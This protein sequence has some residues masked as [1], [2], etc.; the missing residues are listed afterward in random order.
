MNFLNKLIKLKIILLLFLFNHYK[1]TELFSNSFLSHF[2]LISYSI[3]L[4][5]PISNHTLQ[6]IT[7]DN[8]D[9]MYISS[10][11]SVYAGNGISWEKINLNAKATLDSDNSKIYYFA[12]ND[13]GSI[14][15]DDSGH[16]IT[17]SLSSLLNKYSLTFSEIS[18]IKALNDSIYIKAGSKLYLLT[19]KILSIS[20]NNFTEGKIFKTSDKIILY[21]PGFGFI[22]EGIHFPSNL[23]KEFNPDFLIPGQKGYLS[24][25]FTLKQFF[26][27]DNNFIIKK[28]W[29]PEFNEV[30]THCGKVND[31]YYFYSISNY[32]Y[33]SSENGQIIAK[34]D[35]GTFFPKGSLTGIKSSSNKL[36]FILQNKILYF[37]FPPVFVKSSFGH[38]RILQ[39][40]ILKNDIIYFGNNE[41]FFK[42][43]L[44]NNI[45]ELILKGNCRKI[46]NTISEGLIV[47][48]ED[49]IFSIRD[50][51]PPLQLYSG[52]V[53]EL[54]YD[55][56]SASLF[57]STRD[58]IFELGLGG[59][60]SDK[61]LK[62]ILSDSDADL[63]HLHKSCLYYALENTIYRLNPEIK[64]PRPE[65]LPEFRNEAL[66]RIFTHF[67]K[68]HILTENNIYVLNNDLNVNRVE[69]SGIP[70]NSVF[71]DINN[72]QD[73]LCML[74]IKNSSGKFEL[75]YEKSLYNFENISPPLSNEFYPYIISPAG[76]NRALI[77]SG[78]SCFVMNPFQLPLH[79]LSSEYHIFI[80]Q[81]ST[82]DKVIYKGIGF[83]DEMASIQQELLEIPYKNRSLRFELST[84]DHS[85]GKTYYKYSL[86]GPKK[87][88]S[89]WSPEPSIT[90]N[91]L[92]KGRYNLFIDSYNTLLNF[93]SELRIPFKIQS[94]LFIKWPALIIY[95]IILCISGFIFYK[96]RKIKKVMNISISEKSSASEMLT[97]ELPKSNLFDDVARPAPSDKSKWNKYEMITVLFSDIQGFTKIAE[98]MNPEKLVDELDIFFYQF[99]SV[100]EK[101]NIEKIKTIGDAYMAVGGIPR[102]NSTNP[103]EVVLA[104]LEMQ[105]YM[106]SLK[107][108]KIDFW[109]LRIGIHS[110]PVIGGIIGYKKSSYDIWGDTVNTAS[111]MESSGEP[112]KVNISGATYKLIKDFF[113]CEYRGKLPVK[114]KGNIDMY[115]VKS[116]RP[117]LS[118]NLRNIPNKI[119][120]LK[121][122][123]LRLNDLE[124][125]IFNKF[126]SELPNNLYF[127]SLKYIRHIYSHASLL[128]RAECI[129]PEDELLFKTA[130]LLI[131]I[132][133][134]KE[135]QNYINKSAS[136]AANLLP[137][138]KYTQ[139][140]IDIICNLI[141]YSKLQH[142]PQD[143]LEKLIYDLKTEYYGRADFIDL[144]KLYYQEFNENLSLITIQKW[145]EKYILKLE[146]HEYYSQLAKRIMEFPPEIQIQ[147]ILS[148]NWQ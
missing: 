67:G 84:S 59:A 39:A 70:N 3:P 124:T 49:G 62:I 42:L 131:F 75:F 78:S 148:D 18:E 17:E 50:D 56:K 85:P 38:N 44:E 112:G 60:T 134:T 22:K 40:C 96:H 141:L 109:D 28:E 119:F 15:K 111:R 81:I 127:H 63:L 33:I 26:Q 5:Y 99:D 117:E 145:K 29:K 115:F 25:S 76:E 6:D 82:A 54:V 37:D 105:Q 103:V 86:Q 7:F 116:I 41:G 123:S 138:Y 98:Q 120:F 13:A 52:F 135:Y 108:S 19:N 130:S 51:F 69:F 80:Y 74:I 53:K 106:K 87:Q 121:L 73:D 65:L 14:Y 1:K 113:I 23:Q 30:I 11:N 143:Y 142:K 79:N 55:T 104:A 94:P 126:E 91:N 100:C 140:Q 72:L 89:T 107:N 36:W 101:Y 10:G 24:Y 114:Y 83:S 102:Q 90:L 125:Y 133:L 139:K 21:K 110:G 47:L 68:I 132:G 4:P 43:P 48:N 128:A 77:L 92:S 146:K 34:I 32:L 129:N 88:I 64:L 9:I 122:Q 16:F 58:K 35:C 118:V 45:P 8:P 97:K 12:G 27:L 46:L 95:F 20:D 147:N 66:K 2:P 31:F 137:E 71:Y 57:F 144:Y 136:I 61:Q 93:S